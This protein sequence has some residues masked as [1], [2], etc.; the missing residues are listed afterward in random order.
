MS[1]TPDQSLLDALL[2]SQIA[3]TASWSTFS[4]HFLKAGCKPEPW[5]AARPLLGS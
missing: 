1:T 5:R 3:T 4:A 2:D